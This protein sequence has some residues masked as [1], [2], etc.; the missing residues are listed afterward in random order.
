MFKLATLSAASM[1]V[2]AT[3]TEDFSQTIDTFRFKFNIKESDKV[4]RAQGNLERG[5]VAREYARKV[6]QVH[7][8]QFEKEVKGLVAT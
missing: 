4:E 8:P 6:E 5:Q 2:S 1:A 7:G 3:S